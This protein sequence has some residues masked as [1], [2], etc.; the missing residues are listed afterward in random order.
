MDNVSHTKAETMVIVNL[1][2]RL[3]PLYR[4]DLEDVFLDVCKEVGIEADVVGGGTLIDDNGEML[5]CD[6][7]IALPQINEDIIKHIIDFFE[8]TLA[9]KGSSLKIENDAN[10]N[11]NTDENE[12][13]VAT[14]IEFGQHEG[15]GLYINMTDLPNPVYQDCDINHVYEECNNLLE[16]IGRVHSYWEGETQTALYMYGDDYDE[17]VKRIEPFVTSYPLCEKSKVVRIA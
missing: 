12:K 2:A 15:L 16:G 13:G 5:E 14:K 6:I 8:S 1:K 17:M 4:G 3:R 10:T 7:E 11:I 9:P